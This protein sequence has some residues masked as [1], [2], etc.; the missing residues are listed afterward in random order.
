MQSKPCPSCERG[1]LTNRGGRGRR[2]PHR[3]FRELE[4]PEDVELPTCDNC[5][6][7]IFNPKIAAA[8]DEGMS[9]AYQSQL[10]QLISEALSKLTP[11]FMTQQDLERALGLSRG[12]ISKLKGGKESSAVIAG[13]L[14][15]LAV[16]PQA[17]LTELEELWAGKRPAHPSPHSSQVIDIKSKV[18]VSAS[19]TQR[20]P[21]GRHFALQQ[22]GT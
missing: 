15:L 16:D 11:A 14:G 9:R 5:G 2:F 17:R 20:V 18:R 3:I 6:K 13:L 8:F 1:T 19:A 12:Y 21:A 4:L 10:S 7:I 22:V